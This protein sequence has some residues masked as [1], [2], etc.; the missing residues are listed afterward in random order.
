MTPSELST[1]LVGI[2]E[3]Q[4]VEACIKAC[5]QHF[6]YDWETFVN[7]VFSDII[8][9]FSRVYFNEDDKLLRWASLVADAIAQGLDVYS[10]LHS[11]DT[12]STLNRIMCCQQSSEE[13]LES[14]HRW[15]DML[16]LA[17][18]DTEKYLQ[19]ET[20]RCLRTW[21]K[22]PKVFPNSKDQD[23]NIRRNL[24]VQYSRGRRV[25]CWTLE[26]EDQC[27]LRDLLTEFSWT[28]RPMLR[29][30]VLS[31]YQIVQKYQA[32]KNGRVLGL[33]DPLMATWPVI[34]SPQRRTHYPGIGGEDSRDAIEWMR[35]TCD[36]IESRFNRKL[37]RK[38]QK[39]RRREKAYKSY[40]MP[41]SWVH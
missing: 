38:M 1:I 33:S 29:A 40:T 2:S 27:P 22:I 30:P 20:Q 15:V 18:V 10:G 26:I 11:D 17:G 23:S 19:I 5:Q 14:V 8:Y 28:L 16:D 39:A 32:W 31:T 7:S 24:T 13:A 21:P 36:L 9:I 35:R 6:P 37:T 41:G 12:L 25:P 3:Y 34:M 4:H